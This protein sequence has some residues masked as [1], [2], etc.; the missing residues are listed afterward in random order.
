[1]EH[2]DTYGSGDVPHRWCVR[3]E[4]QREIIRERV[5][6]GLANAKRRGRNVGTPRAVVETVQEMLERA[7]QGLSGRE[8][9]K[10]AAYRGR[11]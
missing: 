2:F 8:I 9:G 6:A 5:K 11:R 4:L 1:V 10:V 7:S 3:R